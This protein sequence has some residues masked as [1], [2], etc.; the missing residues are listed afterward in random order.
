MRGQW[1]LHG[2]KELAKIYTAADIFV[3][4]TREENYP[5][6][7]MESIACGTPVI[8]FNTGGSPEIVN[9]ETGV[10][11]NKNDIESLILEINK[12]RMNNPFLV[13][14]CLDY[15]KTFNIDDRFME[16]INLYK[17]I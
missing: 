12:I 17:G 3:N 5:S 2:E 10:V 6:V 13:E 9:K 8:T 7:N 1:D 16:Y 14:K 4:P 15:A 11:I